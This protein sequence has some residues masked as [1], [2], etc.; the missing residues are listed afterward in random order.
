MRKLILISLLLAGLAGCSSP[1]LPEKP[2]VTHMMQPQPPSPTS[3]AALPAS[4]PPVICPNGVQ[5][6]AGAAC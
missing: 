4:G 2:V 3:T 1:S 6:P 5:V